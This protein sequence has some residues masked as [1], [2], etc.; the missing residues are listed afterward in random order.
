MEYRVSQR[1]YSY[2]LTDVK[3]C[4]YRKTAETIAS[5]TATEQSSSD[6][7]KLALNSGER[8]GHLL[9]NAL[10]LLRPPGSALSEMFSLP[11]F[12]WTADWF[13]GSRRHGHC[14]LSSTPP[15]GDSLSH[16]NRSCR[17]NVLS[18]G[19]FKDAVVDKMATCN[20]SLAHSRLAR[21]LRSWSYR[22]RFMG[23]L[24]A[25]LVVSHS[26]DQHL[27]G[28]AAA[29]TLDTAQQNFAGRQR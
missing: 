24:F 16:K 13:S 17:A 11:D 26:K 9:R 29:R 28:R 22:R 14:P 5:I 23:V 8:Q 27:V 12:G 7:S 10:R 4:R 1:Q 21:L 15:S 18:C 2:Y 19:C 6:C 3:R 20:R 25:V